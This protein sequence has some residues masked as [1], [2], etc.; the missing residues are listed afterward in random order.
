[1]ILYE[2]LRMKLRSRRKQLDLNQRQL[3]QKMGAAPTHVNQLEVGN[4][5]NPTIE[6]LND[7]ARSLGGRLVIDVEFPVPEPV[8]GG[9]VCRLESPGSATCACPNWRHCYL[10]DS[11][12]EAS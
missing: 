11:Q 6:T 1:M 10:N 5:S 7:W 12:A 2:T 4:R 9:P 8:R 3:A